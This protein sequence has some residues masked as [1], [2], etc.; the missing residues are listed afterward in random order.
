MGGVGGD[1]LGALGAL[2]GTRVLGDR[3]AREGSREEEGQMHVELSISDVVGKRLSRLWLKRE[4]S[5]LRAPK[6]T[7]GRSENTVSSESGY[8]REKRLTRQNDGGTDNYDMSR[9]KSEE[10]A[11]NAPLH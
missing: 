2:G 6:R 4:R 3:D 1:R 9:G 10:E 11:G 8:G 5:I 7:M